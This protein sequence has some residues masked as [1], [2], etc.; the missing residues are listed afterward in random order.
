MARIRTLKPEFWTDAKIVE[1][2]LEARLF[3]QGMWNFADDCGHIEDEPLRLK[4]QILPNDDFDAKKIIQDLLDAGLLTRLKGCLLIANFKRHQRIDN[5]STCRFGED[6]TRTR[7]GRARKSEDSGSP[8][9]RKVRE[10]RG[11]EGKGTSNA[12]SSPPK[13]AAFENFW[14]NYPARNGS[15]GSKKS[16]LA[17]WG[18]LSEPKKRVAAE[19]LAAYRAAAGSYPKD[20]VRYLRDEVWEGLVA[21]G[22][23]PPRPSF[24]AEMPRL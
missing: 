10:G 2:P 16:A 5:P 1:L 4:L 18:R 12:P 6:S 20:A 24:E 17:A 22:E 9:S 23:T 21:P 15:R 19:S 11:K 8:P 14:K 7:R 13:D 3:F